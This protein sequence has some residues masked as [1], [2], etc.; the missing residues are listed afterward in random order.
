MLPTA[1]VAHLPARAPGSVAAV[2]GRPR[3]GTRYPPVAGLGAASLAPMRPRAPLEAAAP[4]PGATVRGASTLWYFAEGSSATSDREELSFLNPGMHPVYVVT[5]LVRGDGRH[6]YAVTGV[7]SRGRG[8]LEAGDA[9]GQG[10]LL[11]AVVRSTGPIYAERA[12]YHGSQA[13]EGTGAALAPGLPAPALH[14]YLPHPRTRA[15]ERERLAILN[16]GAGA[17]RVTI[18]VVE[19]GALRVLRRVVVPPLAVRGEQVPGGAASAVVTASGQGVVVEESTRY[20]Q[21]RG[22][23]LHSGL[24]GLSTHAFLIAPADDGRQG[25]LLLLN[26]GGVGVQARVTGPGIA[27]ALRQYIP[28]MGQAAV[29]LAGLQAAGMVQLAADRPIAASYLGYLPPGG[30]RSLARSYRGSASSALIEPASDRA[31][32]AGDTRLLLSDPQETLLLANPGTAAARIR[33]TALATGGRSVTETLT[34][35]GGAETSQPINGWSPPSQH[36]LVV[37]ADHPVLAVLANDFNEGVDELLSS[38][39]TP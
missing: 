36:G 12:L 18:A 11:A 19:R 33:L 22:F 2:A 23:T 8:T 3:G 17:V 16:P 28:A 30:E 32:A 29:R 6:V 1:P 35:A 14:W 15:D 37:T 26:P 7:P 25:Y 5:T 4:G 24:T 10:D 20:A 21:D 39:L 38:G 34:L 31:F 9:A 13:G 27:G